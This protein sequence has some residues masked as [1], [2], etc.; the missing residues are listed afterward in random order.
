MSRLNLAPAWGLSPEGRLGLP[1]LQKEMGAQG[2]SP[3]S[4]GGGGAWGPP[5]L[6]LCPLAPDPGLPSLPSVGKEGET[7]SQERAQKDSTDP[8]QGSIPGRPLIERPPAHPAHLSHPPPE[9]PGFFPGSG[10]LREVQPRIEQA[11]ATEEDLG[12]D[13]S[14]TI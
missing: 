1:L 3:A 2:R 10:I 11:Q 5:A 8:P 4:E 14:P 7:A 9:L 12:R 13:P 6:A